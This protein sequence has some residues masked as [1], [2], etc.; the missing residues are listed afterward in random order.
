M[1]ET[2]FDIAGVP[3]AY[4]SFDND[5]TIYIWNG[6]PVAYLYEDMIYGFNGKHLGWYVQGEVRNLQ[7]QICGFNKF[8]ADV[9][10]QFEPYKAYKQYSPYRSYMEYSHYK[11]YFGRVK[12]SESLVSFLMR[13]AK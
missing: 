2:L 9:Y 5:S 6:K 12:S 13:G 1:E 10:T 11:P 7:G 3:V 4:I 8:A